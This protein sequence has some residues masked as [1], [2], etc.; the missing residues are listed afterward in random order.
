MKEGLTGKISKLD[1]SPQI[2]LSESE[3]IPLDSMITVVEL[4]ASNFEDF[5]RRYQTSSMVPAM[6]NVNEGSIK[7][8]Q[9]L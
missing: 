7:L 3:T 4:N 9:Q 6:I 2:E 8:F 1:P 5:L